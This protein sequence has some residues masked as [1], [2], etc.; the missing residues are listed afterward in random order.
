MTNI[1]ADYNGTYASERVVSYIY[2]GDCLVRRV[3]SENTF[4]IPFQ[5]SST[6]DNRQGTILEKRLWLAKGTNEDFTTESYEGQKRAVL[7]QHH[8][9]VLKHIEELRRL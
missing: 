9:M 4:T 3:V 6:V 7:K 5:W 8:E 2:E 1:W